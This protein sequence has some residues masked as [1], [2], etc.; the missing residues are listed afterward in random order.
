MPLQSLI[1]QNF[2]GQILTIVAA[3]A[4]WWCSGK[5]IHLP[6]QEMQ[7]TWVW[8]LGWEDPLDLEMAKHSSILAGKIPWTE[9]TG[10]LY[11]PWD[12]KESDMTEWLSMHT[13]I[14][15]ITPSV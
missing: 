7:E 11:S 14:G 6:I 1:S 3:G 13:F 15:A 8:S 2:L 5:R 10:G 4:S 9:E 12:H